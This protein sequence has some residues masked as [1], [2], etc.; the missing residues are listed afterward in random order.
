M[1]RFSLAGLI[2]RVFIGSLEERNH[3]FSGTT[4]EGTIAA[5]FE[6]GW[7]CKMDDT[8]QLKIDSL[9]I[10][11]LCGSFQGQSPLKQI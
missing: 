11:S 8:F 2:G 5:K 10:K 3:L 9:S 1:R 4:C 7:S 6:R